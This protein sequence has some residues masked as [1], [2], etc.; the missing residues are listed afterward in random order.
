MLNEIGALSLREEAF[1]DSDAFEFLVALSRRVD[2]CP[3]FL[4]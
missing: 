1:R 4:K 2:G 3:L